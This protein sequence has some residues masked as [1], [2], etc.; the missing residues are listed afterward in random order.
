MN[1]E[2]G[3]WVETPLRAREKSMKDIFAVGKRYPDHGPGKTVR[4]AFLVETIASLCCFKPH[5]QNSIAWSAGRVALLGVVLALAGCAYQTQTTGRFEMQPRKEAMPQES[6]PEGPKD[7]PRLLQE[8][9]AELQKANEAQENG[10]FDTAFEH[11]QRML[12]LL[13]D[14]DLDPALNYGAS[15][16]FEE[17]LRF[18]IEHAHLYHNPERRIGSS[19]NGVYNDIQIP[20]PLPQPVKD[21]IAELRECY[22]GTFQRGL[23]RSSRYLPFIREEFRSAGL[24]EDLAWLAMVESMFQPKVVS[25]AGAG[26]MWQF[27]R[28]TGRRYNLRM[29]SY[30]DERYNWHSATQAAAEYLKSLYDFFNGDWAL[31]VTAYNMG[32]GGLDRAI[33][34][35]GGQ[36]DFWSLINTPPASERIK[37]ESK[38]YYPRLLAYMIV[39]NAPEQYGF[40]MAQ[41]P[42]E[43]VKRM[44]VRGS[45]CLADLDKALGLSKGTLAALNPDLVQ[46]VTPPHGEYK[47]A[48]PADKTEL[49]L[50]ALE[51]VKTIQAARPA[52]VIA[53]NGVTHR[54]R[55]GETLSGIVSHYGVDIQE[56][57]RINK[58]KSA[59]SLQT[60]QVLQIPV[61][62]TGRGGPETASAKSA[63][64]EEKAAGKSGTTAS[65]RNRK[66]EPAGGTHTVRKGDTLSGIA[67]KYNLKLAELQKLNGL[68]SSDCIR[69]GQV[70][71]LGASVQVAK[72]ASQPSY[73]VVKAGEYPSVIA[74]LYGMSTRDLL[75]LNNL[76][77]QSVIRVGDR[78]IVSGNGAGTDAQVQTAGRAKASSDKKASPGKSKESIHKVAAGETASSI[79][80]RYGI[81]T[82][83][84]LASNN[85]TAKSI[86]RVG[87]KLTIKTGTTTAKDEDHSDTIQVS[88]AAQKKVVHTV[89]AGQSPSSIARRYG[90][91]LDDLFK[92]NNWTDAHVLQVG[93]KV[94]IFTE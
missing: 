54:V 57:M 76:T 50:A 62:G 90:V 20:L 15:D 52:A 67:T 16:R 8:A 3:Y 31:A 80:A 46:E 6:A 35:N 59:R 33:T 61:S 11:Y 23:N 87:Q 5:K 27:M 74:N 55:R 60:N 43:D 56:V 93:E 58:I 25:T 47:V 78:L 17:I 86:L 9:E 75:A 2:S 72:E 94:S 13:L 49:F 38:K 79:A 92:W 81:K 91:K 83:E 48:V 32:E 66:T 12:K 65:A 63:A 29:D 68:K 4:K 36:R 88:Q 14:A 89:T 19:S 71:Q 45:Y 24:P 18:Y 82:G 26:G 40:S 64:P 44:P 34:A 85:L 30:V 77:P 70:L 51:S 53:N 39:A 41:E 21:E 10:D 84:L 22:P 7:V 73:H 37:Q 28:A 69:V 42:Y 1:N